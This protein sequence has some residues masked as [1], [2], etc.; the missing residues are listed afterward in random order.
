VARGLRLEM[1]CPLA[2][3]AKEGLSKNDN[4]KRRGTSLI[5]SIAP[6]VS[7]SGRVLFISPDGLLSS[8]AG[9]QKPG[10]QQ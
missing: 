10:F 7:T 2:V 1:R 5:S 9:G 4:K 6:S 8:R 3:F